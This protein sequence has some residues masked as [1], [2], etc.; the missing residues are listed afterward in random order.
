[1]FPSVLT[2]WRLW[3]KAGYAL[4]QSSA[5]ERLLGG[6]R[7]LVRESIAGCGRAGCE[8]HA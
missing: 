1:M 3:G 5:G 4:G 2:V 8:S 6:V 7:R